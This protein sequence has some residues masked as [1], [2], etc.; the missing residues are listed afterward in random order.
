MGNSSA[1]RG[2]VAAIF[3]TVAPGF[4]A[5]LGPEIGGNRNIATA[6]AP[7]Y[8]LVE[9]NYMK[10]LTLPS[11]CPY[12]EWIVYVK[13]I[14]TEDAMLRYLL[15]TSLFCF[16]AF[17]AFA[18]RS[19]QAQATV[20]VSG[21]V[22][23]A[24]S[25]SPLQ[26]ANVVLLLDGVVIAGAASGADGSYDISGVPP[27]DYMLSVRF[28][29][30]EE[31]Q[32]QVS[33]QPGES[34]T[35]DV[36]LRPTGFDLNAVVVSA[37]RSSEK[38]LDAPASISVLDAR[39]IESVAL[40]S[41]ALLLRN[42]T[43]VDMAQTGV[44]RYEIVLRGF[45]NVFSGATYVMTDYRRAAVTSLGLN[46]YN[47][48]PISQI[49]LERVEVVRGPGSALFGAGV[50]AGVIHFISKDPFTHPGT[51][52]RVGGGLR[53][54][55]TASLR[56]AG[57]AG[58]K[59][60]YK[61]V[62]D[63]Q[64]AN[65]F[66]FDP[67]DELDAVQLA[68]FRE[69]A[70]PVDYNNHNYTL[71]GLLAWRLRPDV[72][73]TVNGGYSTAKSIGLSGIGTIQAEGFGYTYGQL[74]LDAGGF[75]AQA[76]ANFNDAGDSFVYREGSVEDVV[77][78]STL[79]NV[80]GQY[81]FDILED[82]FRFIVGAE[83]ELTNPV[84]KSTIFGRNDDND[85]FAETGAYLQSVVRLSPV[86]NATLAVRA[87]RHDLFDGVQISPRAAL[88]FKPDPAHSLRATFN[89]AFASP[90]TNN[91]FLDINAGAAGPLTIQA[92]GALDGFT[93]QRDAQGGL[94]A[95][96]MIPDIF[97]V[98][99]PVGVPLDL[100]YSQIYGLLSSIPASVLQG[101]LAEQGLNLP[102]P[103]I[104]QFIGLLSP[105]GGITVTGLTPASIGYLDLNTLRVDPNSITQDV[106]D[107][108][109]LEHTVSEIFEVGYKGLLGQRLL[110]AVDGYYTRRRNFVSPLR[111]ETPFVLVPEH[112]LLFS[113]LQAALAAGIA[114]NTTLNTALQAVGLSADAVSAL[115]VGLARPG[116]AE[117]LPE[118]FPI[119]IVQ[120]VEN[121]TPG[122][123]LLTYRSMGEIEYYG[124]DVS[125]ELLLS[126]RFRVFGNMSWVSDNFFDAS[127][128]GE[129]EEAL[130]LSMN[131]AHTKVKGGF[132]YESSG[133]WSV[134][135]SVR[136][137]GGFEVRSGLYSGA[138]P[139]HTL[140]D[141]GAGYDLG[142]YVS[143]LRLN[144]S[145]FNVLD[146]QH[147]EFVG[148]PEIGRMGLVQMTLD[149]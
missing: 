117:S 91:L 56:H 26:D 29:G 141:V 61:V 13:R 112:G 136:Y 115:I 122:Q 110:V 35:A 3:C 36:A 73:L 49:D 10:K 132:A 145:M 79:V 66:A 12:M 45:N 1:G 119:G 146:Q 18:P 139:K 2:F 52:V 127:E 78:N 9:G 4:Q 59:L 23:D 137:T 67:K 27:G 39:E 138:V 101:L 135:A 97:G 104:T 87:D 8:M 38:V 31:E 113:D 20:S 25:A 86:L 64:R 147:R 55:L 69:E 72:T 19:V 98:P 116:F 108:A 53:N 109:P 83:Y 54:A 65:D 6:C 124:V 123:L 99:V 100:L 89:R 5:S 63:F 76:Y 95:S 81:D 107:V 33:L 118:N 30:Y 121:M 16:L 32:M 134:H 21:V 34:L 133:N 43:G 82:R 88:V 70:L 57:V 77:D 142:D 17:G 46:A 106:V 126:D 80:Q 131:S 24:S 143:G 14:K 148:S 62:A 114:D 41:S 37:S 58:G 85:R 129:E 11:E 74:R 90:S 42:V 128:L 103:I 68:T 130:E 71:S 84:T 140:L 94:I 144:L 60:G 93:F 105:D 111:L 47:L 48:M 96:S 22:T 28:V 120:P 51:T 75:F 15:A 50:D 125:T 92:R 7:I 102:A 44:N 149:I 40:P